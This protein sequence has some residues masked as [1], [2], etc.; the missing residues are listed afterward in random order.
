MLAC[1][2]LWKYMILQ[3]DNLDMAYVCAF[4][5]NKNT[6]TL[7]LDFYHQLYGSVG[8]GLHADTSWLNL[9]ELLKKKW[10]Q[11]AKYFRIVLSSIRSRNGLW[12]FSKIDITTIQLFYR[13]LKRLWDVCACVCMF[14]QFKLRADL[15]FTQIFGMVVHIGPVYVKFVGQRHRSKFK[16]TRDI[17]P[18][19]SG[20]LL[21]D[22]AVGENSSAAV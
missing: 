13:R 11:A 14:K 21:V 1:F 10:P 19:I 18:T 15:S 7:P 2:Q 12:H 17:L 8:I 6:N 3:C 16:V 20:W 5:Q 4:S 9:L 22:K